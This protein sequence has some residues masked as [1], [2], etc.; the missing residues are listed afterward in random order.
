[1]VVVVRKIK[2]LISLQGV[3]GH[4]RVKGKSGSPVG[5]L[6]DYMLLYRFA[7]DAQDQKKARYEQ[8][9]TVTRFKEKT[10]NFYLING[11]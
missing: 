3:V 2:L 7:G 8:I 4:W 6:A 1:M 5:P 9:Q 11:F 10:I